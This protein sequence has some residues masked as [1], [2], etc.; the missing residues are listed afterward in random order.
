MTIPFERT[1]SL[2]QTKELLEAMLDPKQTPRMPR[3]MRGRAK[4]LLRHYPGL[5]EIERAH[6]ALPDTHGPVPPFL[7]MH[8]KTA[9][10]ELGLDTVCRSNDIC[11]AGMTTAKRIETREEEDPYSKRSE[12]IQK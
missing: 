7:R 9:I 4:A 3:W 6:E 2:V 8:G 1:R 12:S 5:A 10:T 11:Q